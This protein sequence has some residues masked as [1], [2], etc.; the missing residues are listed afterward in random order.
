M[1]FKASVEEALGLVT[2]VQVR[3]WG[4]PPNHTPLGKGDRGYSLLHVLGSC[5][6]LALLHFSDNLPTSV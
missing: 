5:A 1:E 4:E 6:E 2:N 3:C